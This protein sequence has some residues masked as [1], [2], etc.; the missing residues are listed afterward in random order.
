MVDWSSFDD[1]VDIVN[2]G[3]REGRG[4]GFYESLAGVSYMNSLLIG[5][6]KVRIKCRRLSIFGSTRTAG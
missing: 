4:A 3:R 2:G 5:A 6:N 1:H